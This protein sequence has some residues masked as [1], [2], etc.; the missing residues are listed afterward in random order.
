MLVILI[1]PALVNVGIEPLAAHLFV[2]YFAAMSFVTPPVC[3]ACFVAAG[4]AGSTPMKTGFTSMR[5]GIAAYLVPFAFCYSLGLLLMGSA[6]DIVLAVLTTFI[7]VTAIAIALSGY[8]YEKLKIPQIVLFVIGGI[9][10]LVP[11]HTTQGIGFLLIMFLFAWE[12]IKAKR[13]K[14]PS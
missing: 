6:G 10:L 13:R 12:Y 4:I 5:L 7:A 14:R 1:A 3:I 11:R 9:M 2:N 8:L